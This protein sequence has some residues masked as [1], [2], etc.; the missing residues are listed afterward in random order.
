MPFYYL[1]LWTEWCPS[2]S[3]FYVEA[4]TAHVTV[5]GARTFKEV[6]KVKRVIEVRL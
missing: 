2:P 5:F 3:H 6:I 1:L 4:L